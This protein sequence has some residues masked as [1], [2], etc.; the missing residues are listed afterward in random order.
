M[1]AALSELAGQR[2]GGA[3]SPR[4]GHRLAQLGGGARTI[5][6]G[7]RWRLQFGGWQRW[8]L[9]SVAPRLRGG[10]GRWRW[11]WLQVPRWC[12]PG[13]L[14]VGAGLAMGCREAVTGA[15]YERASG[16]GGHVS[17]HRYRG[18]DPAGQGAA[19]ALPAGSGRPPAADP[20][21]H[22]RPRWS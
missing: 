17:V 7:A 3:Y 6:R 11:S 15:G 18:V 21:R 1:V 4:A 2:G 12:W 20:R 14:V 8:A 19:G 16:R 22:R 13:G 10:W 5:F 9:R